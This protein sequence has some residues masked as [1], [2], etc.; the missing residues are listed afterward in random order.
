MTELLQHPPG[1]G[2]P[3]S[4]IPIPEHLPWSHPICHTWDKPLKSVKNAQSPSLPLLFAMF[5]LNPSQ[6][7]N[8]EA[9][10]GLQLEQITREK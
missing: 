2:H 6:R 5:M 10:F 7:V 8:S 9:P 4:V 3:S 1:M